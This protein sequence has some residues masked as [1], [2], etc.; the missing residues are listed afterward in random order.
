MA[1]FKISL[2]DAVTRLKE[3]DQATFTTLMQHGS[4]SVEY[5]KPEK[6]DHQ[7]PHKQDELYIIAS[8]SGFFFRNGDTVTCKT[9]DVLFVPA[10]MEHR[11]ID[12]TEDFATWVIFYGNE[13]GEMQ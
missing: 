7:Q 6:V 12:F 11:F 13:G 4:M 9:G 8:G 10:S 3:T 5:Y 1:N 2:E